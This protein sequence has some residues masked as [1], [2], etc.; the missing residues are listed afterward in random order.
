MNPIIPLTAAL[1]ASA[2]LT[3]VPAAAQWTGQPYR[4]IGTEP[5]WSVEIARRTITY[6]PVDGRPVTVAKPRAVATRNGT[7][8]RARGMTI[9]ITRVRC[10]DGMS[11][12]TFADTVR[13]TIGRRQLTGCGGAVVA[14]GGRALRVT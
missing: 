9:A 1:A 13:V 8:Y 10:S 5:F 14:R 12:H 11:D 4:A 6:R 3:P 7:T 2:L